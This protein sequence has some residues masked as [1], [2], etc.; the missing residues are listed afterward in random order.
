MSVIRWMKLDI[1]ADEIA[2]A[3]ID[4]RAGLARRGHLSDRDVIQVGPAG[5]GAF[6][7][8]VVVDDHVEP[9]TVTPCVAHEET[10]GSAEVRLVGREVMMRPIGYARA[11]LIDVSAVEVR[12]LAVHLLSRAVVDVLPLASDGPA[13]HRHRVTAE[14][15][16]T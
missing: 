13:L 2:L 7:L 6:P 5:I 14:A 16:L 4:D 11:R 10:R 8:A 15:V 3:V 1:P 12:R 9:V